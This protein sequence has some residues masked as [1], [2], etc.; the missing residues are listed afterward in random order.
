MNNSYSKSKDRVYA[1]MNTIDNEDQARKDEVKYYNSVDYKMKRISEEKNR[2]R[3]YCFDKIFASLFKNALPLNNDYKV[4]YGNELDCDMHNFMTTDN[5]FN[6]CY[7]VVDKSCKSPVMKK[8]NTYIESIVDSTFESVENNVEDIETDAIKF[9]PTSELDEKLQ[10]ITDDMGVDD[11]S[12]VISNNVKTIAKEEIERAKAEKEHRANIEKELADNLEITTQE[13]VENY[14]ELHDI[15]MKRDFQPTL[16]Q[17]IMINETRKMQCLQESGEYCGKYIYDTLDEFKTEA[18]I[19][20]SVDSCS[21][22]EEAFVESV[23][24]FTKLSILKALKL[25]SFNMYTTRELATKYS[26]E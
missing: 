6:K 26:E 2:C 17:G 25:E 3:D 19:S 11:V 12:S 7:Y 9:K 10:K 8:L 16:F 14:M 23:K 21:P 4:A 24:E 20:D 15:N 1:F 22:M 5:P 18:S 13:D